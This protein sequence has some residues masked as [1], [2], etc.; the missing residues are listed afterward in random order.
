MPS[1]LPALTRRGL[2]FLTGSQL[3]TAEAAG[4]P[5]PG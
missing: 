5:V 1:T 2:K 3:I 4:G